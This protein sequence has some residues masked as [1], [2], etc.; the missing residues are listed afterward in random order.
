MSK[1]KWKSLNW[2]DLPPQGNRALWGVDNNYFSIHSIATTD[3]SLTLKK[4][5]CPA[6]VELDKDHKKQFDF[7]TGYVYSDFSLKDANY[8]FKVYLPFNRNLSSHIAIFD[9]KG[10]IDS[11]H[12][13]SILNA[14]QRRNFISRM[15]H[16]EYK[17]SIGSTELEFNVQNPN[18]IGI[19]ISL[20][21]HYN[22]QFELYYNDIDIKPI[23]LI[24]GED[25]DYRI[26]FYQI[27]KTTNLTNKW[28]ND[29]LY[30]TDFTIENHDRH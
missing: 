29:E 20:I 25:N 7:A 17:Y 11:L 30:I 8:S 19:K 22:G 21:N 6:E 14:C 15:L 16:G 2:R 12:N 9:K 10:P 3:S 13:I 27:L 18:D 26:A 4:I 24:F 1:F 23:R 5:Y 28:F